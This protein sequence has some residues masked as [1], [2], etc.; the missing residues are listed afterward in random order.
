VFIFQLALH[1]HKTAAEIE[2]LSQY[3]LVEWQEFFAL[4][5]EKKEAQ[6]LEMRAVSRVK[7]G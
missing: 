2:S 7:H 3:E 4:E 5:S 1:L 6:E